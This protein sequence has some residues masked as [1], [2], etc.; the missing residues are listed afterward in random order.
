MGFQACLYGIVLGEV[1]KPAHCGG[2]VSWAGSP[3]LYS[4]RVR[5]EKQLVFISLSWLWMQH[6][7]L[8]QAPASLA[9]VL[10]WTI[11]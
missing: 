4:Q 1:G 11:P 7:L 6:D 10:G 8:L 5:A 9:S 2:T 3:G